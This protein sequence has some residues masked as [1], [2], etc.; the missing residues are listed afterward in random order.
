MGVVGRE[1]RAVSQE[2]GRRKSQTHKGR[3]QSSLVRGCPGDCV[4]AP[5]RHSSAGVNDAK[6]FLSLGQIK[7]WFK[8]QGGKSLHPAWVPCPP[9]S[10]W[11]RCNDKMGA[12][13]SKNPP[14]TLVLLYWKL[15]LQ[16]YSWV[17]Y[18][19]NFILKVEILLCLLGRLG[20][21][22]EILC[23]L[24]VWCWSLLGGRSHHRGHLITL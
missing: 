15:P 5:A 21:F 9:R 2:R 16:K 8:F 22:G 1:R 24:L 14:S 18:F 12:A 7:K 10:N 17:E 20:S 4:P 23:C 11:F 6:H 19:T 3:S 13:P